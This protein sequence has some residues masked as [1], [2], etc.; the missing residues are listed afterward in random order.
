MSNEKEDPFPNLPV[1]LAL[2]QA[3]FRGAGCHTLYVK[4]LA[5]DHDDIEDATFA[6]S[7]CCPSQLRI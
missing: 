2:V 1:T 4:A 3:A 7:I 6:E 5:W